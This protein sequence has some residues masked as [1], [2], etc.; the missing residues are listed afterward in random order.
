MIFKSLTLAL[1]TVALVVGAATAQPA[2]AEPEVWF[3]PPGLGP[4]RPSAADFS[5]LFT[6]EAPWKAAASHTQVFKFYSGYLLGAPQA[7][8]N[9]MVADLNRRHIAI[10]VEI[11]V[12]DVPHNPPSGCGGMGNVEG[13]GIAARATRISQMIK[14]AHGEIKYIAM[15][16]P[17]YYGHYFTSAPGKGL[18]CHSPIEQ[19][20]QLVKPTLT[21]F[22]QEFP[23]VAIGEI[24]PTLFVGDQPNWRADL[25]AWATT[26]RATMGRPLAFYQLDVEWPRPGGA[27]EALAAYRAAEQLRDHGLIGEIGVIYNGTFQDK[28]D[29][30]WV[31][32]AENHTRII[33]GQFKLHPDQVIFQSWNANPTHVLPET[34]PDTMTSLVDFYF[35][36]GSR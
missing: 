23:D 27:Q 22:I 8:I 14:A 19:I 9:A 28:T 1:C 13:Y 4:Q 3:A 6:P 29:A 17:F 5:D 33:E 7:Q 21:N 24:E 32:D 30:A 12:M 18:G 10:A 34:A 15:D 31:E 36:G 20:A 2:A 35:S 16:E 25:M 26:Y 11:G